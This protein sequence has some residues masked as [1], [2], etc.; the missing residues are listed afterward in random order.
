MNAPHPP[1]T[2]FA[3]AAFAEGYLDAILMSKDA[4]ALKPSANQHVFDCMLSGQIKSFH[5]IFQPESERGGVGSFWTI[6]PTFGEGT[7]WYYI[8]DDMIA[9][10]CF[11]FCLTQEASFTCDAPDLFCFGS[12][13]ST[14]VPYF[15]LPHDV[16]DRTLIGYAWRGQN[17][18]Q[19]VRPNEPLRVVSITMLP[20]GIHRMSRIC[21]CDPLVLAGALSSLDGTKT[22]PGMLELF[23]EIRLARPMPT[24]ARAYYTAKIT[25]ACTLIADW[26]LR[27]R[28]AN[29]PRIRSVDRTALNLAC[30]LI[31]DNLHRTVTSEELCR[32]TCMS[33]S[34]L[35]SLFKRAEGMT[36]QAW[37]RARKLERARELLIDTDLS[38]AH[39]AR[40]VGY[41][42]Q[43]SFTE[44]F[45]EAFA[46][47]PLAYRTSCR[48]R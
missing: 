12:Y 22:I 3:N 20:E 24:T 45:K 10:A 30:R 5:G 33:E 32:T 44:A 35:T 25:E 21:Q 2:P 17:Y 42:R 6:D 34:K 37:A 14:M 8:I 18:L 29:L 41:T 31:T 1:S 48:N 39:I 19:T 43:G 36:P 47:T 27:N 9:I 16:S 40:E 23:E 4:A 11:D 46:M 7:Y 15:G 13:S 28:A 26:Y 38:I